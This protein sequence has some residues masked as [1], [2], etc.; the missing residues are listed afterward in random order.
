MNFRTK[1]L[2]VGTTLAI[3]PALL[4]ATYLSYSSYQK[5]RSAIE[6]LSREHLISVRELKKSQ[7]EAYFQSI[8]SQVLSF[9]KDRMI[10]NAMREFR[11]GFDEYIEQTQAYADIGAYRSDVE[12]YYTNEYGDEYQQRNGGDSANIPA[13]MKGLDSDSIVLQHDFISNNAA[14][15]GEKDSLASLD[16]ESLYSALHEI[17]HPPIRDYLQRFEYY[18]IFLVAPDTGDIVYSVFKEL[19]FSTSLFDGPYA[20]SGIARV[21]QKA[22]EAQNEDFVVLDDFHP[23]VPS[24]QDPAAFIASPIFDEGVIQGV[25]IFQMPIDRINGIMTSEHRWKESGL[26]ASGETYLVGADTRMRSMSRFLIED[27]EGYFEALKQGGTS[28]QLL[29]TIQSKQTSI[30]LQEVNTLGAKNALGGESGFEIFD[31]YRGVPVLSAYAPLDI[32]G[33]DWAILSEIDE[34]EAFH[35]SEALWSSVMFISSVALALVT[36]FSIGLSLLFANHL[37][38]PVARFTEKIR[39][40]NESSDLTQR[41]EV[42]GKD[43]IA[44]SAHALN[45]L[46]EQF[47]ATVA[48]LLSAAQKLSG[49]SKSLHEQ[50]QLS[51]CASTSQQ[52]Q[53][54]SISSAATQLTATAGEVST[55]A[56]ATRESSQSAQALS[57][58]GA[59]LIEGRIESIQAQASNIADIEKELSQVSVAGEDISRVLQVISDIAEQTNL[60][61]LNAA[62]EAAR[63]GEQGRGFAVVADEVRSLA[64]KTH[65]STEE[66]SNTINGLHDSIKRVQKVT[67]EGVLES[68]RSVEGADNMRESLQQIAGQVASIRE[69]NE[70]VA[71]SA[72]E[73][74]AVSEDISRSIVE[75]NHLSEQ[76]VSTAQSTAQEAEVVDALVEDLKGYVQK[77][78]A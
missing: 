54:E 48:Y 29:N 1:F 15:L 72:T 45:A 43:E 25:L 2:L 21:F 5:G 52:A 73:Q 46:L 14:P 9:S 20:N 41:V 38:K 65:Q 77:F 33:L 61:A 34:A 53:S 40:I 3:V 47:Q 28:P 42:S 18:D 66:I 63:A 50:T 36:V 44:Q 7:I 62:I 37:T 74:L 39:E 78:K 60:L 13:L 11:Q 10:V 35:E 49:S 17:Y 23:Y 69:M 22:V 12:R 4:L 24:Y 19:D 30:G 27:A 56:E 6:N 71:A 75:V 59:E 70:Q 31:D 67:E 16:N 64:Q 32:N 51:L 26:G 57:T 8:E 58:K 68:E 76:N 55:S